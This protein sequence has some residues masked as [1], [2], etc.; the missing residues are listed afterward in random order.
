VSQLIRFG[1]ALPIV[2]IITVIGIVDAASAQT[3]ARATIDGRVVDART[4]GGLAKVAVTVASGG[5][6]TLTDAEGRF[7]LTVVTAG[8]IRL[9]VS[10]VGY[11]RVHRDLQL[12][13][14]QTL[15]LTIPLSEGTGTY[16][17]TVTV[18]ADV[19]RR[20]PGVASQQVLG[21]AEPNVVITDL[22]MPKRSGLE[23]VRALKRDWPYLG[24]II[25]TMMDTPYHRKA[26][27]SAGADAFVPKS[28]MDIELVPAIRALPHSAVQRQ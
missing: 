1:F 5:P 26:A 21:S 23:L 24:V 4:G 11:I 13:A 18:A 7:S 16:T 10:V 19:F 12:A 8:P 22:V 20:T 27:Q 28:N 6:E 15:T 2:I 25:M 9:Y 14:G 17:E 3:I